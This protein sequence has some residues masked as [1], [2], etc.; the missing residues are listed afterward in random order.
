M[1]TS[2]A[3]RNIGFLILFAAAMTGGCRDLGQEPA[4][5]PSAPS[6]PDSVPAATVS[7]Q[8]D[9]RPI[10]ANPAIGCLGCHGGSGGLFLG[11]RQGLITGGVH[12]AAVLPGNSAESLLIK[13][14]SATPPFGSRMPEGGSPVADSLVQKIRNWID[15]GA[16]DN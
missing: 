10:F 16:L 13:K 3:G 2:M 7:F 1:T 5:A 4:P 11:T 15:Q 6:T 8:N 14:L 12:G 9:I